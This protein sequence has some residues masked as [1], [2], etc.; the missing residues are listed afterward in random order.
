MNALCGR[1]RHVG[2][3]ELAET[4]GGPVPRHSSHGEL[5]LLRRLIDKHGADVEAM[6]RDRRLNAAQRTAGELG[7]ALRKAGLLDG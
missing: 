6:A 3:Q 2:L 7:R 4:R 5:G 1:S